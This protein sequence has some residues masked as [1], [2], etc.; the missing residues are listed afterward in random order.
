MSQPLVKTLA[1]GDSSNSVSPFGTDFLED[2]SPRPL[3]QGHFVFF[4]VKQRH[5]EWGYGGIKMG[6]DENTILWGNSLTIKVFG[7]CLNM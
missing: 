1:A 4:L 2:F 7:V 5:H 3:R 6:N